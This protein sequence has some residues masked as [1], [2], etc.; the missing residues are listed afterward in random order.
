MNRLSAGG[1]LL[2]FCSFPLGYCCDRPAAGIVGLAAGHWSVGA[3]TGEGE[4]LLWGCRMPAPMMDVSEHIDLEAPGGTCWGVVSQ[5]GVR[6][7]P[8]RQHVQHWYCCYYLVVVVVHW[9]CLSCVLPCADCCARETLR[10]TSTLFPSGGA[11]CPRAFKHTSAEGSQAAGTG[12]GARTGPVLMYTTTE[13]KRVCVH[14]YRQCLDRDDMC[15][16]VLDERN[17]IQE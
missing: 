3:V 9:N 10:F 8:N 16:L 1:F 11:I 17:H 15:V 14:Y 4:A 5:H 2:C 7:I 6:S 12:G 13:S